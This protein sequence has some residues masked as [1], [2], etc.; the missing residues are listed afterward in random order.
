LTY[1][2]AGLVFG[3]LGLVLAVAFF[4]EFFNQVTTYDDEGYFLVTVRQ[5]LQHG[6]LYVHTSG[7]SYGPFYWSFI[8][9]IYRLTGHSPTLLSGRLLV[10][11]RQH[12]VE[13]KP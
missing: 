5:F 6:S 7:A 4:P 12:R 13:S 1:P 9:L 3:G 2:Q 10:L 8:G 11:D